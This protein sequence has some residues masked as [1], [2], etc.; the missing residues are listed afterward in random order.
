GRGLILGGLRAAGEEAATFFTGQGHAPAS[1]STTEAAPAPG[2][3]ELEA[4]DCPDW[5]APDLRVDLGADFA[6]VMGALRQRAPVFLR[7]NTARVTREAAATALA[8]EGIGTRPHHLAKTA[9]EVIENPR[10]I[11][12]SSCYETGVVELQDAASQAVIEALPLLAGQKVLDYCAGG[13]GKTLA[14]A[15]RARLELFAHDAEPRRMRDLPDRAARAGVAVRVLDTAQTRARA[16]YD[17]VLA[18]VPCSG[19]GSWRRTPE[20]KWALTEAR[21]AELCMIQSAIL[22]R[23][24]PLVRPGGYLAYATC[25]MLARENGDQIRAFLA[26]NPGWQ[27]Q[28]QMRLTPLDGGDGFFLA[29]LKR[30]Q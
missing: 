29:I 9:L 26:I 22:D 6:P 21:L 20:A 23:L 18:D 17:L 1:L 5:L 7:V 4:L 12:L 11:S 19:S 14:M 3:S 2:M 16:P 25:S 30:N 15:A 27:L 10:K 24:I 8:R 28:H 13:G